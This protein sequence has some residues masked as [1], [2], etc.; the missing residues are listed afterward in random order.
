MCVCALRRQKCCLA[1]AADT[2]TRPGTL[3]ANSYGVSPT[4]S[5]RQDYDS[6][7]VPSSADGE[8]GGAARRGTQ[9]RQQREESGG[10]LTSS[11]SSLSNLLNLIDCAKWPPSQR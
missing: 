4:R 2:P 8:D 11:S 10:G 7:A 6:D 1:A 9:R 3:N 5:R